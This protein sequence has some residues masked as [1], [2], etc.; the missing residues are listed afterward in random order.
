MKICLVSRFFDFRNAGIGRVGMEV[1][2][3]LRKRGYDVA[4]VSDGSSLY[5]Y[6]F[7]TGVELRL[8]IPKADV[9]HAI[10]PMEAMW[11]PK[12]KTVVT[13]HDIMPITDKERL[14]SGLGGGG[15]KNLVG[16]KY[17]TYAA[18]KAIE[19]ARIVAVSEQTRRELIHVLGADPR[20]VFVIRSGIRPDLDSRLPIGDTDTLGYLGQ[21]DRRKRVDL[22]ISTFMRCNAHSN[23]I[24]GGTGVESDSLHRLA[25]KD[26]RVFFKGRIDDSNLVE[27]YNTIDL[28]VFPTW[29]EGYGLPI[30]EAMACKRPVLVLADAKIP[31]EVKNRCIV[32]EDLNVI[33]SRDV[34]HRLIK[35]VDIESNYKWA[36]SHNWSGAI[37]AYLELY[38]E[39][40]RQYR[41]ITTFAG[42]E[43]R[44]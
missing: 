43:P 1:R 42:G 15:W 23:L 4:T 21:L 31:P 41:H 19:C 37:D 16:R 40:A 33:G 29:V 14:G 36:K 28:F 26:R 35:E 44:K 12:N 32:V 18:K 13:F 24:I 30:V 25:E 20:K 38:Q 17:F 11:L 27:F 8:K 3:G 6:F 39:I 22:L 9:Y 7:Y 34:L 2:D 5:K 10:T